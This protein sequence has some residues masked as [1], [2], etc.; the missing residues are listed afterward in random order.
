MKLGA[1]CSSCFVALVFGSFFSAVRPA[2]AEPLPLKQAVELALRHSAAAAIAGADEQRAFASYR[3]V[4]DSYFPQ[5]V[6]GSGLGAT[7][8]YPLS[9]EG[10]APS[11][12]NVSAQS[13]LINPALQNFVRAAKEDWHAST[14]QSKDQRNQVVQDTVLDY[15]ELCKWQTV[16]EHLQH[17]QAE[18]L[19]AEDVVS[20]RIQAGV[21][22]EMARTQAHLVSAQVR[23]RVARAQS[24]IELLKERLSH[25]TGLPAASIEGEPSSIPQLP[26]LKQQD[27]VASQAVQSSPAVQAAQDQATALSFRAHGEHRA[28]WPTIDF[29]AQYAL[30]ATYNNYQDFFRAGSFQKHNATIGVVI[31]FPFLNPSQHA[32]AQ[33]A[34][35]EALRAKKQVES[36]KNQVSEETLRL[37]GS[38]AQLAAAEDVA[39]LQYQIAQTNLESAKTRMVAGT[40]TVHDAMDAS[41]QLN[42]SYD[43]L[44]DARFDLERA[45]ITLLRVTGGLNGWVGITD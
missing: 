21:D 36:T 34:D 40:A 32:R 30:L 19:K 20:Q 45:R 3:Q 44:Q 1:C 29:A 27:D 25:R 24:A 14:V 8:G 41:N 43:A 42:T 16:M 17:E 23:L 28:L 13:S 33:A 18:A 4:K 37:Q 39:K 2:A 7:W 26:E 15:A 12:I 10:S 5:L 38:V 11:I 22:S 9:L 6:L 35:A 31:R